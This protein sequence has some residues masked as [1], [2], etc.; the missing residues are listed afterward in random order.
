MIAGNTVSVVIPAL[1]EEA[2]VADV[3]R[4][5]LTSNADEVIVIDSDSAD[6]TAVNARAAGARVVGWRDVDKQLPLPGKG[7]ALWRGVKAASGDV[8]VF[9]DADV[10]NAEPWWVDKLAEPFADP[11][12]HLVKASYTRDGA[13]GR[14]TELTAKPLLRVYFPHLAK[15]NQPLAGEYAIR[16]STALRL[17]FVAGYG[18]EVGLLIDVTSLHPNPLTQVDLGHRTHRNRPLDQLGPMADIVARTVLTRAGA[19]PDGVEPVAQRPPWVN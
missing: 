9:M 17:P 7:E 14:V 13:G 5:C 18:V 6:A 16:R 8:V 12:I 3:V 11:A 2:T 1:N 19:L 10:T 15:L 4:A